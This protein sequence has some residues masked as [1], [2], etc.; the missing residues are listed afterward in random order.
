MKRN[1]L[2]A[3][4]IALVLC[5]TG[6]LSGQQ[7]YRL[8]EW[9]IDEG[10]V[11]ATSSNYI[12]N[13][14]FHQTTI[15]YATGGNYIA[16]IGFWH[17]RPRWT[18][19]R[20]VAA[21]SI[22]APVG[23]VDTG[24]W[25]TPVAQ[26]ASYSNEEVNFNAVFTIFIAGGVIP[27]YQ[28]VQWVT[29]TPGQVRNISF[30]PV[31]MTTF[32]PHVCRC[33]VALTGDTNP[34]NDTVSGT[35]KV[36]YRFPFPEGWS[37][38][39]PVPALPSGR[40]LKNGSWLTVDES[41]GVIY[42]AKANKTQDFYSYNPASTP[43]WISLPDWP[44]GRE[45]VKP[46]KGSKGCSGGDGYIYAIKGNNTLGFWRY[47][48]YFQEWEQLPD[49]PFGP[50]HRKV[51]DGSDMLRVEHNGVTYIYLLKGYKNEFYRYN[52]VTGQ[53]EELPF[54]P[55]TTRWH[56]GSWLVYD[57]DHTI[58]AHKGKYHEFYAFDLSTGA[59]RTAPLAPMPISS[60]KMLTRKRAKDGSCATWNFQTIFALKGGNTCEFWRYFPEGDS[61]VELDTMPSVGSIGN[62][63]RVRDGADI[64]TFVDG[65]M[66][67]TKGNKTLEFWR[68]TPGPGIVRPQPPRSGVAASKTEI[69]R[70]LL[71]VNSPVTGSWL[72][73]AYQ[74]GASRKGELQLIDIT[75][76]TVITQ[77]LVADKGQT[78]LP[79]K[80]VN[81]GVYILRLN[82]G[83]DIITRK[84]IIN[85]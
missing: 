33:S 22:I 42:L 52:T 67:A 5:L 38:A 11:T 19:I 27:I 44:L 78:T 74:L 51:K 8:V 4:G 12:A 29:L 71:A 76:R 41:E 43:S 14:S 62:K 75:G 28:N 10:G 53:W 68:F 58:Y 56:R 25:V 79:L 37:E 47:H 55:G 39:E 85:R 45:N 81:S 18:S 23:G 49:V 83:N 31:R 9:V 77:N 40:G 80:G 57:G 59:W 50:S 17:P 48:T 73:V 66:Y 7:Q 24:A 16:W 46:G 32:G 36:M 69:S 72:P 34:V 82:T 65:I 64:A 70:P 13:G 30:V 84:V 60:E 63:K 26:L 2:F 15:G 61:W 6:I 1:N 35:C 3:L 54:A 21:L 20:D